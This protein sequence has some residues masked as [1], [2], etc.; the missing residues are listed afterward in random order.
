[1]LMVQMKAC[2]VEVEAVTADAMMV[3][4]GGGGGDLG[5]EAADLRQV[6]FFV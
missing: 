6:H 1:M 3:V 5:V 4:A 2:E